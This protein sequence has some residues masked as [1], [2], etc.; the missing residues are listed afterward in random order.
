[1]DPRL[2]NLRS[3]PRLKDRRSERVIPELAGVANAKKV[4][5]K[6]RIVETELR[7]LDRTLAQG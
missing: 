5:D 6:P 4:A 7:G 2:Q 3:D 1:M